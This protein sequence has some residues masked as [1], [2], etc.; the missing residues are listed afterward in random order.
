MS[1]ITNEA[2]I[3]AC[4][5]LSGVSDDRRY[6]PGIGRRWWQPNNGVRSSREETGSKISILHLQCYF[7]Q[8]VAETTGLTV[9]L[10]Y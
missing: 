6:R 8:V 5:K 4:S 9:W 1:Q 7:G 10:S 3:L 2:L